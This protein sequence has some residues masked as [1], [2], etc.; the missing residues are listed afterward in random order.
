MLVMA[1]HCD[2]LSNCSPAVLACSPSIRQF[3][4]LGV[5]LE[6]RLCPFAGQRTQRRDSGMLKVLRIRF[7]MRKFRA[8][9]ASTL[10]IPSHVGAGMS[11]STRPSGVFAG[12]IPEQFG[13]RCL[14]F[15]L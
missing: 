14:R 9:P 12:K 11:V 1:V 3:S 13:T 7:G 10:H 6:F 5:Y 8:R 4:I 2:S 15:H